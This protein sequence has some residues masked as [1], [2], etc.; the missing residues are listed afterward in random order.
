MTNEHQVIQTGKASTDS[1]TPSYQSLAALRGAHSALRRS[2]SGSTDRPGPTSRQQQIR[3]FLTGA[4]KAGAFIADAQERRVAQ[5]ILDFWSAELASSSKAPSDDFESALLTPFDA[6]QKRDES[7]E[8]A[9]ASTKDDQHTLIR[10]SAMA[11]QWRDSG[12]QPGY[13]LTGETI[14]EAARFKNRDPNLDEFIKA[15][16][17]TENTK[18]RRKRNIAYVGLTVLAVLGSVTTLFI[19]QFFALPHTSKSWIRA[20]NVTTSEETQTDNL[21]WLALS[22]PWLPPYDLSGTR[23]FAN[24]LYPGLKLNAPNFSTVEFTNVKLPKAQLFSASFNGSWIHIDIGNGNADRKSFKWYDFT[25]WFHTAN[26][27]PGWDK[28]TWNDFSGAELKLA[29]Y[30]N[31][32]IFTTSFA[33]A[34]LYRAVFDR[35]LLCDV[36]FSNADLQNASFWGATLD[37]RTYGWLRKTAWWVAVGWNSGDFEKLLNPQKERQPDLKTQSV[38]YSPASTAE[39]QAIRQA[40]RNSERFHTDFE[41]PI[42]EARPGTFERALA[43]NDM[44]W[45]L[46]TWGI[47]GEGLQKTPMPCDTK[48]DPKDALEAAS[49]AICIVEDLKRTASQDKDYDYWLSTFRDTQAYILM[50][51]DRM[52]EA[53]ALYEKDMGRTEKDAGRL[54]RYAVTLFAVGNESEAAKRF[55]AAIKGMHYLPRDELQNLKQYIPLSVR[56]MAYEVIDMAYPAPKPVQ[57]CSAAP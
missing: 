2:I 27:S 12:K 4:C 52:S 24:I 8:A 18:K 34:D 28:V 19:W 44:A 22:Q 23:K 37:D 7:D 45:T 46:T 26:G 51:A 41:V 38:G 32:Q 15:S 48:A 3:S 20:I 29:Q 56:L 47:D 10:L 40:L 39:A 55:E 36:N 43:L 17:D 33:G 31:A 49:Q 5:S 35:A 6:T 42:A 25:R 30:R 50:Q 54:F 13:L 57:S 53:K 1:E 21:W 14:E 16:E 11:R 9:A